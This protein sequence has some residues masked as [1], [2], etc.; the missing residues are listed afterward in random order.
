MNNE[1]LWKTVLCWGA[2][3]TFLSLPL[4]VFV[5]NVVSI[6]L[7]WLHTNE[8]ISE[9]KFVGQFFQSLTL[10]VFGLAGLNTF[11]PIINRPNGSSK[12]Q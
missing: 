9:F 11:S 8:H 12:K 4:I 3:I 1:P 5:L 7:S 6:E 2:V 10:L